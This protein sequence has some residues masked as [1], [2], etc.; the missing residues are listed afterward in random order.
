[1]LGEGKGTHI[2]AVAAYHSPHPTLVLLPGQSEMV[3]GQPGALVQDE[4]P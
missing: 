4:L 3:S 1:M 2:L